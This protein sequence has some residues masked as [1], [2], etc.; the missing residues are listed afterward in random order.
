MI[1]LLD[2]SPM[3]RAAVEAELERENRYAAIAA[4]GDEGVLP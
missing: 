2:L 3:L 1:D 4:R